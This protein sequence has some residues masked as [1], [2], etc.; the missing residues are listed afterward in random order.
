MKQLGT[1]SRIVS[2]HGVDD[3]TCPFADAREMVER[4]QAAKLDVQPHFI[5]QADL[6][7]QVFT[8]SGHA[9]GNRTQIVLQ[10]AGEY[11]A[12]DGPRAVVRRGPNDFDRGDEQVRYQTPGGQFVI[13]YAAGFPVGRFEPDPAAAPYDE[14]QDLGYYRDRAGQRRNI[15]TADDWQIR[16]QHIR[17]NLQRVLGT[18]PGESLRVPLDMRVLE[19]TKD[20]KLLRR[21][22]SFQSD[23]FDRVTAW[24]LLPVTANRNER[25]PAML[26]LH[27]TTP[28]GKNET[29][30]LSGSANK[31]YGRELAER[32]Y[33]VLAPDYP[34]FGEHAYDF[35]QHPE[36]ASGSL[37]AVWDNLRAVDLLTSLPEVDPERIGVIGHSLGGHNALFTAVFETRLKVV[38]S[39]CGYSTLLKDDVPS[40]S[41][42]GYMPRIASQFANDAKQVP[43]DFTE[44]VA[45]LAPRPSFT[46]AATRDNDFDV[47][48]VR[49]VIAAAEPIYQLLGKPEHLQAIY[50]ETQHDFPKQAREQGYAF[51]DKHLQVQVAEQDRE[52]T[53]D[54]DSTLSRMRALHQDRKWKELIEQFA[55]VDFSAWPADLAS[56][57]SE[58]F[59]LRGQGYSLLKDGQKAE[60][61]LKA[62]IK[63]APRNAAL[64][65]TLAENST[66]NLQNDE[67]AL[68]A[69]RQ[70]LAIT[71]KGNGWEPLTATIAMARLLTDEVKT[72]EALEVL[73]QYGD[74]EGM[75]PVWR[76][77][78]LRAYGH[79]YAAQGKEQE[80]LARF[81][82]VA[83]I[84]NIFH[85]P[86]TI[87]MRTTSITIAMTIFLASWAITSAWADDPSPSEKPKPLN[88][89]LIGNSQCPTIVNQQLL[90]KLA[91]SDKGGRPIQVSGCIKGGASL[92]SHWEA[93]TGPDTARG[94]IA[95][96]S[97][98]YVVLQDIYYV[99]EAAFQPYARQFHALIKE[100]GSKTV[101][102]GTASILSDYPQGFERQHRLHLAMGQE[103]SV[104]IVD[105]SY[106]YIRYFGEK[107]A[108]KRLE[109]LFA[110]DRAHPGLWGSYLYSCML[111]SVLTQAQ[112]SRPRRARSHSRGYRQVAP[113]NRLGSASSDNCCAEEMTNVCS[114]GMNARIVRENINFH[115]TQLLDCL[116]RADWGAIRVDARLW[117]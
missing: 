95:G 106:A 39:S 35:A 117:Q 99:E 38:V 28:T 36:F 105:A 17:A 11:L 112:S 57:A 1:S 45:S 111:Y 13:S 74:M 114:D 7:G 98:D 97:W 64:W 55:A 90:E 115:E 9:L 89:L 21:K 34:S 88:I 27:Q 6:D 46:S 56:K 58:A 4:M 65:L 80:S 116:S 69:Y 29:V 59:H 33:V 70:A 84:R 72:D 102:F 87:P 47:T 50:P 108:T 96:G 52:S 71:G 42:P 67:Q 3:V 75:A 63:L 8:S 110:K 79:V 107:P 37:K 81:R 62:A 85:I 77:K 54:P 2:V 24:L 60:A 83:G 82:E 101:L 15:R 86:R 40:W 19:E 41:G 44:I 22:I 23:P 49:D 93:G 10:V 31:H 53:S 109:S 76:I 16:R 104:P 51:L 12:P 100:S 73:Q 103:L 61:D 14:H 30:G 66:N 78:M 26:C 48:G 32:G 91:A 68:A 20:E 113:G 18:L 5:A 43:F 92:R 94:K 25:R